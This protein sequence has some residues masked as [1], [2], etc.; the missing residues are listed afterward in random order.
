MIVE[1]ITKYAMDELVKNKK[2]IINNKYV[3][4]SGIENGSLYNVYSKFPSFIAMKNEMSSVQTETE[5]PEVTE[6]H[7]IFTINYQINNSYN[8]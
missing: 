8:K 4:S 7:I 6:P 2:S 5:Q 3:F 1:E